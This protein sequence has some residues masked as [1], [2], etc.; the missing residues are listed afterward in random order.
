MSEINYD[1][2]LCC[3]GRMAKQRLKLTFARWNYRAE[4]FVDIGGNCMGLSVIESAVSSL[5]EKLPTTHS[6][7]MPYIRLGDKDGN[8]L[9]CA[10]EDDEG[11]E[12]LAKMLIA[13]EI[14]SI[15]P[16]S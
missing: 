5:Y 4:W 3:S 10:D 15:E 14:V 6:Y 1:P 8:C 7:D 9:E 12:W 13:A 16:A 2:N 11:E